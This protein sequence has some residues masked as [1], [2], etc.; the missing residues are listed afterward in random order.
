MNDVSKIAL[1]HDIDYALSQNIKD[2]D[3]ADKRMLANLESSWKHGK[4]YKINIIPAYLGI[5]AKRLINKIPILKNI[6]PYGLSE[7]TQYQAKKL[8]DAQQRL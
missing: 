5:Q 4:D 3:N 2:V 7:K 6:V 1:K 8:Q